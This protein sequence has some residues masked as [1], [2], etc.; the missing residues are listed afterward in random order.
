MPVRRRRQKRTGDQSDDAGAQGDQLLAEKKS[1]VGEALVGV[2]ITGAEHHG[3]AH[4]EQSNDGDKQPFVHRK[5]VFH[6]ACT[7]FLNDRPRSA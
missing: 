6:R 5:S 3:H 2:K 4:H 7:K 1:A